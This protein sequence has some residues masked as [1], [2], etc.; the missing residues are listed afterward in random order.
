[1]YFE[2]N[3]MALT[4]QIVQFRCKNTKYFF[5][6]SYPIFFFVI[7]SK[8][9]LDYLCF[10]NPRFAKNTIKDVSSK[11]CKHYGGVD[12]IARAAIFLVA[13]LAI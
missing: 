12:K 1:M 5:V 11:R 13:A 2:H 9:I 6:F 7:I 8:K 3:S 10:C 4:A